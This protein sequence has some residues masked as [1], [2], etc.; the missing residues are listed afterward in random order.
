MDCDSSVEHQQRKVRSIPDL[1]GSPHADHARSSD[2]VILTVARPAGRSASQARS[3]N[4]QCCCQRIS[5][6]NVIRND[7]VGGSNPSC[8]TTLSSDGIGTSRHFGDSP[9]CE[10]LPSR[11]IS[12]TVGG[13]SNLADVDLS[14]TTVGKFAG[15]AHARLAHAGNSG[16]SAF[17]ANGARHCPRRQHGSLPPT[18]RR[19][20]A[21]RPVPGG[22]KSVHVEHLTLS[23]DLRAGH[24]PPL[25]ADRVTDVGESTFRP[26]DRKFATTSRQFWCRR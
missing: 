3:N 22:A 24:A 4:T 8:G 13:S 21:G 17:F 6:E 11:T 18:I 26:I 7:G 9:P 23:K 20:C 14:T 16:L 10:F 1:A 12:R 19:A 25:S 2:D 15:H 5:W